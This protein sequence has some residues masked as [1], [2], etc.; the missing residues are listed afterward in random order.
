LKDLET[1]NAQIMA[2][3]KEIA[4]LDT[5]SGTTLGTPFTGTTLGT[6]FTF[7]GTTLGTPFTFTDLKL[8]GHRDAHENMR[9]I[10]C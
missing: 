10:T 4:D 5:K 3:E 6:P 8:G 9:F 7:T 2:V 1:I